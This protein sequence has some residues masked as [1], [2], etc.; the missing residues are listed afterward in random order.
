MITIIDTGLGNIGAIKN[1]FDYLQV[2]S[3]ISSRPS[4][5]S[6]AMKLVLPGV[7]NFDSGMRALRG[8]GLVEPINEVLDTAKV[9][10]LGICL[11]MQ[12]LCK[13]SDE[14]DLDGFGFFD[15]DV[16]SLSTDLEKANACARVPHMGWSYVRHIRTAGINSAEEN[17]K[18]YFVHSYHVVCHDERDILQTANHGITITAAIAKQHI[19]G[20]QYHPE[21][22]HSYGLRL[23][24]RF[25][26]L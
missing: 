17:D 3:H 21:K 14:G 24:S 6:R 26:G 11:G 12:L 1:M 18:F 16:K 20:V 10:F 13:G 9:P 7:G 5:I 25:A 23:F 19:F 2:E 22:S 4:D 15:A 8:R